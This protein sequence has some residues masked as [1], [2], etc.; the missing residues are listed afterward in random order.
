VLIIWGGG[1]AACTGTLSAASQLASTV[2]KVSLTVPDNYLAVPN[3]R[4]S[5][6]IQLDPKGKQLSSVVFSVDFDETWLDFDDS[7]G[8]NDGV[9]DAISLNLPAGYVAAASYDAQDKDGE[10]DVVVYYPGLAPTSLPAGTLLT[11]QL[12]AGQPQSNFVA[13]VKSSLDP[14]ASFGSVTG[15]SVPGIMFDGSAWILT[16]GTQFFIPITVGR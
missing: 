4:V 6:P 16:N 2:E 9:P 8:N 7:D 15:T 14:N 13:E 5:L 10:I 12:T 1:S 11:V 3:K